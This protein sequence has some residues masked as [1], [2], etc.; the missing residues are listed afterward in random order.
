MPHYLLV[1][2]KEFDYENADARQILCVYKT[3]C[4]DKENSYAQ[5]RR[6]NEAD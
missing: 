3:I 4:A 6:N 2:V 5:R 1:F